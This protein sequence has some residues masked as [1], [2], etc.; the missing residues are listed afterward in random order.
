MWSR[1]PGVRGP[2]VNSGASGA[3]RP[4]FRRRVPRQSA[5][6][7]QGR[8]SRPRSRAAL[9]RPGEGEQGGGGGCAAASRTGVRRGGAGQGG[10]AGA[11]REG[12]GN[13]GRREGA[14]AAGA[15]QGRRGGAARA[16]VVA[17]SV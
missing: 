12:R 13:A 4:D 16:T 10:G 1:L 2:Q 8:P 5:G 3:A 11:R 6:S 7:P 17:I 9:G 14:E 15:L